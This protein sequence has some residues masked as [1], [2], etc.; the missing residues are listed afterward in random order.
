MPVA[1][2]VC[3][4]IFK[5]LTF[6]VTFFTAPGVSVS[7]NQ[8]PY[9]AGDSVA[10]SCA[11]AVGEDYATFGWSKDDTLLTEETTNTLSFTYASTES[12]TYACLATIG[13]YEFTSAT[14][15]PT[16]IYEQGGVPTVNT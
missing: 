12:G 15:Q 5:I 11:V 6:F 1:R 4:Q 14:S 3:C 8:S 10:L 2:P 7:G 9:S 13:G 16:L